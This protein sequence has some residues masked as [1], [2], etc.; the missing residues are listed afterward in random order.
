MNL[1]DQLDPNTHTGQ[2]ELGAVGRLY[3]EELALFDASDNE[4]IQDEALLHDLARREFDSWLAEELAQHASDDTAFNEAEIH[5]MRRIFVEHFCQKY[6]KFLDKLDPDGGARKYHWKRRVSLPPADDPRR[7]ELH[8]PDFMSKD[9]S[10]FNPLRSDGIENIH[11]NSRNRETVIAHAHYPH[12]VITHTQELQAVAERSY[13]DWWNKL[14]KREAVEGDSAEV[15]RI[16]LSGFVEGYMYYIDLRQQQDE[17]KAQKEAEARETARNEATADHE[18]SADKGVV[19]K[20]SNQRN[21]S[22][23][24]VY[25]VSF[26]DPA[27]MTQAVSFI[28]SVKEDGLVEL[29]EPEGSNG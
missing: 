18:L 21:E 11:K 29:E 28:I 5:M 16:Y 3:G 13:D 27:R 8:S 9:A 26:V 12:A 24:I 17:R 1:H 22:D 23:G 25:E 20:I 4:V 2:E 7:K 14:E 10:Y 19:L 6:T 15:K